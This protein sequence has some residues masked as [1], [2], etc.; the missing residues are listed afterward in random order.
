ME[1]AE[2]LPESDLTYEIDDV[3][4]VGDVEWV[5]QQGGVS[6]QG[7]ALIRGRWNSEE[8]EFLERYEYVRIADTDFK[9]P[10]DPYYSLFEEKWWKLWHPFYKYRTVP[11]GSKK[12]SNQITR[13]W[14]GAYNF[15]KVISFSFPVFEDKLLD[16]QYRLHIGA[17]DLSSRTSRPR[18]K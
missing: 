15:S 14:E 4:L 1:S 16:L 5:S 7:K 10:V 2:L 3:S 8:H 18:R 9:I 17:V 13:G 6:I 12:L 11:N